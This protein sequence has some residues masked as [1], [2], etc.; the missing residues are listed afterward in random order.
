M[1]GVGGADGGV[2][3]VAATWDVMMVIDPDDLGPV[4]LVAERLTRL[5][6]D[7]GSVRRLLGVAKV[8]ASRIAFDGKAANMGWFAALEAARQGRLRELVG[9]MLEEYAVDPWLVGIYG[10]LVKRG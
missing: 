5:Y 2:A 10:R 7:E 1:R 8:D 6:P 3:V 9:C 4:A